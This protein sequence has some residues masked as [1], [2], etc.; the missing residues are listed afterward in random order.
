ML[1]ALITIASCVVLSWFYSGAETGGYALN[2]I[3][4]R[5]QCADGSARASRL[6]N[7]L[8]NPQRF[9]FSVLVG[10]NIAIYLISQ[11]LTNLYLEHGIGNG[12]ANIPLWNAETAATLTLTPLLFIFAEVFPKN[13]FRKNAFSL[14]LQCTYVLQLSLWAF[15][16]VT[17]PL[18]KLFRLLLREQNA[19]EEADAAFH[20]SP[21]RVR[22]FFSQSV[23]EGT[24]SIHQNTMMEN[25]ISMRYLPVSQLMTPLAEIPRV[26]S[27]A[28][29]AK[30]KAVLRNSKQSRAV[31]YRGRDTKIVGVV[32]LF[33]LIKA[34]AKDADPIHPHM[35]RAYHLHPNVSLQEAFAK[36][37]N[38]KRSVAII[39]TEKHSLG[40]IRLYDIARYIAGGQ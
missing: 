4:L 39:S 1:A 18:R 8:L 36:L 33:D 17:R 23:D 32:H 21:Q 2:R 28:T 10:N 15:E 13:L 35:T 31:V 6:E 26:S 19:A 11:T 37:R 34:G 40:Q 14:M 25:V 3:H 9:V 5:H 12:T 7:M 20:L 29:V 16:P 24:M 22:M 30:L 27:D 38:R